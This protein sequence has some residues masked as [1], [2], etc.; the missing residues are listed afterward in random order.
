MRPQCIEQRLALGH[1]KAEHVSVRTT[2]Q[3][4][5]LA[6]G[7]GLG[8]DQWMASPHC[9]PNVRN[10]LVALAEHSRTVGRCVVHRDLV[11]RSHLQ[12]RGQGFVGREHIG[13]ISVAACFRRRNLQRVQ[14]RG[15]GRHLHV[16]HVSVPHRLA[17]AEISDWLAV[18]DNIRDTVK[19]GGTL[20]K[21]LAKGIGPGGSSSPKFLLKAISCGSESFWSW[22][23]TTSRSRHTSSIVLTS[24][25][26]IGFD[27]SSPETSAPSGAS[28]FLMTRD[29]TTSPCKTSL[30]ILKLPTLTKTGASP[31]SSISC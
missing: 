27:K 3:K 2:P 8:A 31:S 18:F 1:L 10:W 19:S 25:C 11:L 22:K 5:R 17:I 30:R 15:L 12:L 6:A 16:S 24:F 7:G 20:K 26:A 9:L 23:T 21:R 13:K 29:M 4:E 28:R 14:H